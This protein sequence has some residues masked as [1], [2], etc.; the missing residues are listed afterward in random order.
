MQ[1]ESPINCKAKTSPLPEV[2]PLQLYMNISLCS[3]TSDL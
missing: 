3:Y 2:I 1:K